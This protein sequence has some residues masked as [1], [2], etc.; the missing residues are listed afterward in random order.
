MYL[1]FEYECHEIRGGS[2]LNTTPDQSNIL[3]KRRQ[4]THDDL[5]S[6]PPHI[7]VHERRDL[8][9]KSIGAAP[10]RERPARPSSRRG[11]RP[12]VAALRLQPRGEGGRLGVDG[13]DDE[14]NISGVVATV[15]RRGDREGAVRLLVLGV[16]A[17][18]VEVEETVS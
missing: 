4:Q 8:L 9:S 3:L 11:S 18:V 14:V 6:L 2:S 5:R 10:G 13:R 17:S 16:E 12:E 1:G 7:V 15:V